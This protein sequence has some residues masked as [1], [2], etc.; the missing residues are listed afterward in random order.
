MYVPSFEYPDRR[1]EN[2]EGRCF[3]GVAIGIILF[4]VAGYALPPGTVENA[5][6]FKYPVYFKTIPAAVTENVVAPEPNPEVMEQFIGAGREMIQQGCRAIVGGCGYFA[7]YL[8]EIKEALGV[9]CFL[10][11][12]MQLP[13]ILNS[14]SPRRKIG[15]ICANSEVLPKAKALANCGISDRSRLVIRGG[16]LPGT[17]P[18]MT[19]EILKNTGG[20]NPK[21][22]EREVVA[23]AED[24]VK[25]D[26]DIGAF[27]LECTLY[28]AI[29]YAVQ[30]SVKM[31]VY[32]FVTL[33]DW[34]Y[35]AVVQRAYYGYI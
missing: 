19:N 4:G 31:P 9:P 32:D 30:R 12:L 33:I 15:I 23:L 6:T 25:E 18:E 35:S 8:P 13:L 20:Y 14:L 2:Q 17:L 27:L 26:P 24:M 34:A 28:P 11:S 7:N 10:S 29:S 16:G 22:L 21:K 3:G 5:T 1:V